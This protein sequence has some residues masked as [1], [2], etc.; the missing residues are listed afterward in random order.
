[1]QCY[2][3]KRNQHKRQIVMSQST[4]SCVAN[5]WTI[6]KENN[7]SI[8]SDNKTNVKNKSIKFRQYMYVYLLTFK[9]IIVSVLVFN[10]LVYADTIFT[11]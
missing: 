6:S 4:E 11:S 8:N 1:M 2:K 5:I 9:K 10:V 7:R 3:K